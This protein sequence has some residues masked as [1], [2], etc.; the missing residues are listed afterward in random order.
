[1]TPEPNQPNPMPTIGF[2]AGTPLL[3]ADGLKRIEELKPGDLI[4]A[5]PGEER[6]A[7]FL[8]RKPTVLLYLGGQALRTTADHPL[9]VEG[10]GWTVVGQVGG[11]AARLF[12]EAVPLARFPLADSWPAGVRAINAGIMAFWHSGG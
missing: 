8:T 11:A 5:E 6:S 2:A 3:T 4:Q 1:M 7:V 9:F 12:N 10:Q